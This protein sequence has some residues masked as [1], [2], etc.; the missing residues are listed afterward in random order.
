[1]KKL[2]EKIK[3]DP[4]LYEESKRREKER[5]QA[6][7]AA[8][9]IKTIDQMST[10][11]KRKIEKSGKHGVKSHMKTK[12][13]LQENTPPASPI[14]F[15]PRVLTPDES[16]AN[17]SRQ[18]IKGKL[19]KRRNRESLKTEIKYLREQLRNKDRKLVKYKKKVQRMEKKLPDTPTKIVN[20]MLKGQQVPPE[21]K[22]SLVLSEVMQQQLKSNFKQ[23]KTHSVKRSFTS[24]ISGALIKKYRF[25][26]LLGSLTSRR[27]LLKNGQYNDWFKNRQNVVQKVK[28][29]VE[30]FFEKDAI[31]RLCPGKKDT[32]TF[33][34][35]KKQKRYLNGSLSSTY[36]QFKKLYP[37][38][39][40]SY[41][42]YCKFRP[43]WVLRPNARLR[44]T[45]LCMVHD[46]MKLLMTKANTYNIIETKDPIQLSRQIC[47]DETTEDCIN[48]TCSICQNKTIK[49]SNL[50]KDDKVSYERWYSKRVEIEI[51]GKKKIC[52][53][54]VKESVDCSK[55][56]MVE[57]L[58]SSL[59]KF[60]AHSRNIVHQYNSVDQ[61]KK[62]LT[63]EEILFHI[64]FSE[65][66]SC[67]YAS[68]IQSAH[69]GGSKPQVTLHTVVMYYLSTDTNG[70]QSVKPLSLCTFSDNMRHDPAAICAHLEPVIEEAL[71]I[72]P[73]L[74]T[75]F[76]LSDGPSTQY[77]NKKMF[78]LMVNFLAEKL[79]VQ[80]L[81]WIFS[82][83]GHGKG[84]PDGVGGCLKRTADNLVSQGIDIPNFDALISNLM[85][86]C[87]GI[88]CL[89]IESSR[90]EDIEET[91]P[92]SLK[93]FKGTMLIRE[94]TW[95]ELAK[96][97]LQARKL[98][99]L[100]CDESTTC[101]HFP[102]G[103]IQ[104]PQPADVTA[105]EN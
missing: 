32:V 8:G 49:I 12:R 68:E 59:V 21:I 87:K 55:L 36:V 95:S 62:R 65:N 58:N 99:C 53:R 78:F 14:P 2:R 1:M 34:K 105:E 104:L 102:L 100:E 48:R 50:E 56:D 41:Q 35:I 51:K 94:L 24:T 75:A 15:Q 64:D 37:Q 19:I 72:V 30:A 82:E 23:K 42:T 4:V 9:K 85:N 69:F 44:D 76:F 57:H 26:S 86:H 90:I 17:L 103:L 18:A 52:Q 33:H 97:V 67:K 7:K 91:L 5:Y 3:N 80:R 71:E 28:Q 20:N 96:N 25:K 93:P 70:E 79:R 27:L 16:Q 74:R 89:T 39:K 66:Y 61:I 88:K 10:R 31:S 81:R 47:C 101:S 38:I 77:K 83:P 22:R 29:T 54:T 60:M 40:I 98:C 11:E 73:N 84:A 43:F 6:R 13:N 63:S 92:L 45:C 46:N